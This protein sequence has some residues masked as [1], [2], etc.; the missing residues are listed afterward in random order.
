MS[1]RLQLPQTNQEEPPRYLTRPPQFHREQRWPD[2]RYAIDGDEPP[3][4]RKRV[5][6]IDR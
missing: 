3:W 6:P 4:E 1:S 5:P 2:R